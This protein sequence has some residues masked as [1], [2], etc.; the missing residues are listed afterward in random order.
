MHAQAIADW[1][2]GR[3]RPQTE[4]TDCLVA[5]AVHERT[6]NCKKAQRMAADRPRVAL[7]VS[8]SVCTPSLATDTTVAGTL[9]RRPQQANW[10][11]RQLAVCI[12]NSRARASRPV[13]PTRRPKARASSTE[14]PAWKCCWSANNA[15]TRLPLAQ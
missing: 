14:A 6:V 10:A 3:T 7:A 13:R 2:P 12:I 4:A 15:P 8:T 9:D 1:Q 5:L 11:Q